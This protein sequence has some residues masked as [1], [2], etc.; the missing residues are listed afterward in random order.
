MRQRS[1]KDL[2][3]LVDKL[4]F[5]KEQFVKDYNSNS[6]SVE[7][8]AE[9]QLANS[10]DIDATP[11]MFINGEEVV[12]VKPYYELREILIKHGAKRK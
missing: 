4:G 5:D 11:T 7:L 9:L 12:G 10:K 2:L 6:T 3:K 8:E 1:P